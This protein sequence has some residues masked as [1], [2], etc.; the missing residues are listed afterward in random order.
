MRASGHSGKKAS[1]YGTLR[2]NAGPKVK[3][4]GMMTG[5]RRCQ[6]HPRAASTKHGDLVGRAG[7]G[8]SHTDSGSHGRG[9]SAGAGAKRTYSPA[10]GRGRSAGSGGHARAR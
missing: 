3:L 9:A 6:T 8:Y 5:P 4:R 7:N 10:L 1:M 2:G